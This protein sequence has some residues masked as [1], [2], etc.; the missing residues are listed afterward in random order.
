MHVCLLPEPP[1]LAVVA[2]AMLRRHPPRSTGGALKPP[3]PRTSRVSGTQGL[4]SRKSKSLSLLYF[5]QIH[6]ICISEIATKTGKRETW[7]RSSRGEALWRTNILQSSSTARR[8]Q[9]LP[10]PGQVR[11]K[12]LRRSTRRVYFAVCC[13]FAAVQPQPHIHP[14]PSETPPAEAAE[15]LSKDGFHDLSNR[16]SIVVEKQQ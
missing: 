7:R 10:K 5:S 6:V 13:A 4:F 11:A 15:D 12:I 9:R 14:A 1:D 3:A 16:K 8:Q 2:T